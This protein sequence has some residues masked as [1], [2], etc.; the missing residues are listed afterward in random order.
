VSKS[1]L[2]LILP[3]YS[4]VGS[5]NISASNWSKTFVES[6]LKL[7]TLPKIYLLSPQLFREPFPYSIK[8]FFNILNTPFQISTNFC[9]ISIPTINI[10]YLRNALNMLL[11]SL[12]LL[13]VIVRHRRSEISVVTYNTYLCTYASAAFLKRIGF[14]LN[15]IPIALDPNCSTARQWVDFNHSIRHCSKVVFLSQWAFNHYQGSKPKYLFLG[16][17]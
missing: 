12:V 17:L 4:S 8:S 16:S 14:N 5:H 9:P 6:L 11:S 2:I 13:L 15:L 1:L 7:S 10:P 3:C